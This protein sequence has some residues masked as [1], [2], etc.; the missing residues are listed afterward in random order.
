MLIYFLLLDIYNSLFIFHH[1]SF[2]LCILD[3]PLF[4][5]ILNELFQVHFCVALQ[6]SSPTRLLYQFNSVVSFAT[7]QLLTHLS[8]CRVRFGWFGG[9]AQ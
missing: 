8:G 4:P 7:F 6:L 9:Q 1:I 5:D 3:L 2:K